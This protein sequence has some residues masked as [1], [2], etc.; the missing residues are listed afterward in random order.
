MHLVAILSLGS[1]VADNGLESSWFIQAT[2][3]ESLMFFSNKPRLFL[4]ISLKA[5]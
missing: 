4:L 5:D 3:V 2:P 1:G